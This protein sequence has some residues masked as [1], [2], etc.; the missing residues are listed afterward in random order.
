MDTAVVVVEVAV[1]SVAGA[2]A[3]EQAGAHRIELCA[4][5]EL[6][7]VTPGG[8]LLAAVRDRVHIPV[9]VIVRPRCGD[10]LYDEGE[11]A[12]MEHEV[13]H[14]R[15]AG[16]DGVVVGVLRKDGTLDVER[17]ARLVSLARPMAVTCHR[18]FDMCVDQAAALEQLVALGVER[19][20]TSGGQKTARQGAM[21]VAALVRQAAGRI[22]V[23]AGA[24][25]RSDHVAELVRRT[26]VAEV[27][28]SAAV[29]AP[30][31]MAWRNPFVS[32]GGAAQPSEYE[33][34]RTDGAEVA[35]VV[36]AVRSG[37]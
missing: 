10:F 34:R 8:G 3:A 2:L 7:G 12:T 27:H 22:A 29:L 35:R 5:L 6:G 30:S 23:M 24:G 11:F 16:A 13:V 19:V 25:V 20:L 36:A 37:A 33:Q 17:M 14:A 1:D 4:A 32:M 26:G 18:A 28:L 21:Q 15:E 31:A 9:F